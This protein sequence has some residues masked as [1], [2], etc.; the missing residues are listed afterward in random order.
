MLT[1]V[2][3]AMEC[4]FSH[5]IWVDSTNHSTN[6]WVHCWVHFLLL[7][8]ALL[9]WVHHAM[10]VNPPIMPSLTWMGTPVLFILIYMGRT[11][12]AAHYVSMPWTIWF[13]WIPNFNSKLFEVLA[14][15][16]MML[17]DQ[18]PVTVISTLTE[19]TVRSVRTSRPPVLDHYQG[20]YIW[21]I[22]WARAL[23]EVIFLWACGQLLSAPTVTSHQR[24]QLIKLHCI[25][26]YF[27]YMIWIHA[28]I[29]IYCSNLTS[30]TAATFLRC[31]QR[32]LPL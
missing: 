10:T 11:T 19:R 5:V 8:P 29:K 30:D 31:K 4:I 15:W 23:Q 7:L 21:N 16:S 22:I 1:D 18:I 26:D 17:H 14:V 3:H 12:P 6:C 28:F 24:K 2:A 27:L 32:Y 20:I 13:K 25:Y 9:L